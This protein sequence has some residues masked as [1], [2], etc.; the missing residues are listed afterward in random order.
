MRTITRDLIISGEKYEPRPG[1]GY[2]IA[3][4]I[5]ATMRDD[6]YGLVKEVN[7]IDRGDKRPI[8]DIAIDQAKL[9]LS[10]P[11]QFTDWDS[12]SPKVIWRVCQDFLELTL[13]TERPPGES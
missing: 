7:K 6:T 12:V 8:L 10:V 4:G 9:V 1:L 5:V 3:P 13:P 11:K 2:E